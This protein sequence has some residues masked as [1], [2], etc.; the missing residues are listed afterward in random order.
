MK[1]DSVTSRYFQKTEEQ[2]DAIREK[3]RNRYWDPAN[4]EKIR[5]RAYMRVA[6]LIKHPRVHT[7]LKYNLSA[8]DDGE[9]RS[10]PCAGFI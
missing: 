5:K 7:V 6:S 9:G 2:R 1:T 3:A 8:V 10:E 4:T